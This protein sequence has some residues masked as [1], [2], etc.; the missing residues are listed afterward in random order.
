MTGILHDLRYGVRM[1]ASR[2][3][4]SLVAIAILGL[5]IGGT[6][7]V[8][9]WIDSL[10]LRP[11]PGVVDVSHLYAVETTTS[12]GGINQSADRG[13][14]QTSY[15]DFRDYRDHTTL[16]AGIAVAHPDAFTLGEDES[17]QRVWGEQVSGNYFSVL[18]VSPVLGRGFLPSE[19]GDTPGGSPVVVI[20]ERLWRSRF[21]ADPGV[22]GRTLRVNRHVLTIIGVVPAEFRGIWAGL[23]FDLWT[24]LMLSPQLL[25]TDPYLLGDRK[26]RNL[27]GVARLKPG[28]TLP[29]AQAQLDEIAGALEKM[30]P[31]TNHGVGFAILPIWQEHSGA[32]SML[33]S[34]LRILMVVCG[35][36]LLIVCFNLTNMLLARATTRQSE[37]AVRVALGA[38]RWRLAR[39]VMMEV[40]LLTTAGAVV[41]VALAVL[42]GPALTYLLPPTE[43]PFSI[44]IE[45]NGHIL[46][47][48]VLLCL[49]LALLAGVAPAWQIA[50]T[51][52]NDRLKQGGRTLG[53][54]VRS[55]RLRAALVV[56][57]VAL[58]FVAL[59]GAGLFARSFRELSHTEPGFDDNHVLLARFYLSGSGYGVPQR[60]D[61][62]LH[63]RQRM[64]A[65]PGITAVSYSDVVPLAFDASWWE[66]TDIEGY[67]P[68]QGENMKLYRSVVAPGYFDLMSIPLLEGRDFTQ[69]DDE[70]AQ[71]VIIVNQTFVRRYMPTGDPI[72]H[73]VHGWGRW[74][75]VVGVVKD[76]KY[77]QLTETPRPFY[78]VPFQQIYRGDM[79]LSFYV[80]TVGSLSDAATTLRQQVRNL[81]PG[82]SVVDAVPLAEYVS[83]AL[84][85]QKVAAVLLGVLGGL[86][87]LLAAVGLFSVLAY[88]VTQRTHE[89]GIRMALGAR[90]QD[91]LL[92]VVRHAAV[93]AVSGVAA[94][95][96]AALAL[97][98]LL[99][100]LSAAGA[101]LLVVS[102][103]DPM[104]YAACGLFL[105]GISLLASYLPA[106]RAARVD[107]LVSLRYE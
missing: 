51:N 31:R 24:P 77:L 103:T 65:A 62:F 58:A 71:P 97:S 101:R 74:F 96:V 53:S 49:A 12:G 29:Q 34:P 80:R 106:R 40:L 15:P 86:A 21:H 48:A 6:T 37:F 16:L 8:F 47:F 39:Q 107:P 9:S 89:I 41:G 93:M 36:V 2:P 28:V 75:T 63:L 33:L 11:L 64:E 56:A 61:F 69:Q 45:I 25:G 105:L 43:F 83:A 73:R 30:D 60:K 85:A 79:Q 95:L 4:F 70:H 10:L 94:G 42:V 67:V 98:P 1:L 78:Y 82:V 100:G 59:I 84:Y 26:T 50:S 20:S 17:S 55:A 22:I 23:S 68:R 76:S 27:F 90:P 7:T 35:V 38:P 18:G 88:L 44:N 32:Q 57:E 91:V 87:L 14:I 46:G 19:V 54:G 5:G 92:D 102:T 66:D 104:V 3:W 81:D 99:R 52:L 13:Y 72:G